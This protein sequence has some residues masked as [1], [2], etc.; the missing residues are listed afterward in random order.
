[1]EI[2]CDDREFE[3]GL[4]VLYERMGYFVEVTKAT[5]DGGIDLNVFK[6]ASF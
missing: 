5:G 6:R 3:L 1:M 2:T 4:G